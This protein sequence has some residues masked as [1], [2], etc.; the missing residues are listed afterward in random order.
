MEALKTYFDGGTVEK[1]ILITGNI[2]TADSFEQL[3]A[4]G[5]LWGASSMEQ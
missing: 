5:S 4:A 3:K 2:V 1:N